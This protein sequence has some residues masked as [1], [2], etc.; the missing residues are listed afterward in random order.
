ML[1][2]LKQ[3]Y[4]FPLSLLLGVPSISNTPNSE[5]GATVK[6]VVDGGAGGTTIGEATTS[7]VSFYGVTPITQRTS[8]SQAAVVTTV[9]VS[10]TSNIWGFSTSTQ[11]N[12]IVSLVNELRAAMVAI[13]VI[14]GS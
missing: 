6:N 2:F 8:A 11:A 1:R 9:A 14:K 5:T 4:L 13:G 12:S 10:T 7:K 3:I